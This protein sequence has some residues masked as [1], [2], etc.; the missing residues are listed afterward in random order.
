M[1]R[2]R[3]IRSDQGFVGH[4]DIPEGVTKG[5]YLLRSYTKNMLNLSRYESL[6]SIFIGGHGSY[7]ILSIGAL[8]I[9][10]IIIRK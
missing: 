2:V 5:R 1:K 9:L 3:L 4:I 8:Q 10:S 7:Y 6:K